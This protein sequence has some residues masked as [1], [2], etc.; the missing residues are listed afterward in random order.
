MSEDLMNTKEVAQYLG[1]HEKQVYALVKAKRIPSTRIT[2]KWVFPRKLIDEWI[3]SHARSGTRTGQGEEQGHRRGA[4]RMREQRP[5]PGHAP[6]LHEKDLSGVPHPV[7]QHGEHGG[8]EGP[9]PG[10]HGSGLVAPSATPRA[11]STTSRSCPP[12]CPT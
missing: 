8:A 4:P 3:E 6:D 9:E 11:V 10:L 7:G 5:D 12:I 2:G 1:V